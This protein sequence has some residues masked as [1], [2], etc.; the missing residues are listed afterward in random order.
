MMEADPMTMPSMVSMNRVLLA[1][2]LSTASL[3]TSLNI[4]VERALARVRSKE[5]D[6]VT[7]AIDLTIRR[8]PVSQRC[9]VS[10]YP[11][12]HPSILWPHQA[13]EYLSSTNETR[14]PS[15]PL[16]SLPP[17]LVDSGARDL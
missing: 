3:T 11:R 12:E 13:G 14:V 10:C 2:K 15:W 16:L 8:L 4:I 17:D 6:L 1:R 9:T 5:V 7:I